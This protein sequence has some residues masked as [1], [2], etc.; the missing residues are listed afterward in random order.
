M[1]TLLRLG[2]DGT[3]FHGFARQVGPDR[4][5]RTVQGE[6]EAALARLY[7]QEL[8]TR[9]ASRTDAGVHACGQV[10]GFDAPFVIPSRGLLLGLAAN[11]PRDL[12]ASAAW[13]VDE[14]GL[15][16]RFA[17]L[18]KHYRYRV[19]I[20]NLRDP[21]TE[22]FEWHL[23][24]QID[25][26]LMRAAAPGLVGEHDFAGFRAADCQAKTTVRRLRSIEIRTRT[27]AEVDPLFADPGRI[28]AADAI[29]VIEIDVRG[30]AFLKNMVRVIA[31]TLLAIGRGQFGP[32]RIDEVLQ[33]G[34]RS[35]AGPT[36]P[37]QGL[38]LV[39][40]LWPDHL[41]GA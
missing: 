27:V 16:P 5:V 33:S 38:T 18:G 30:D 29:A 32:E 24:R 8:R 26:E 9:G 2:Y 34:D 14:P 4:S 1:T 25:V 7:K 23:P 10:V 21:L 28:D 31:G 15:D 11:L 40:V 19:R 6:L 3:E 39:E 20:A 13:V 17:N 36:A 35:R 12:V 41:R 22:R 37:A